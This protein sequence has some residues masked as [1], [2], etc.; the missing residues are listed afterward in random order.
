MIQSHLNAKEAL[1]RLVEGNRRFTQ[2]VRS[3]DALVSPLRR[4]ALVEAQFPHSIV[5]SCSDSRV[6]AEI[7]FDQGLGDLFVIRVAGN[8]IA[9]SLVGSVELAATLFGVELVVVMGHTR[10][11]AVSAT[12]DI[13][14]GK[15][16]APSANIGEI[17]ERIRPAVVEV[18]RPGMSR[19]ELIDAS[20]RANV[21]GSARQLRSVSPI[22]EN[23]IEEG[24]LSVVGAVYALESGEVTFFEDRA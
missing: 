23:R 17:V 20:I 7:V 16:R 11:G 2:N 24:R 14:Q 3:V 4:D 21:R 8:V 12:V 5:L 19:Q 22:L 1:A 10:C 15:S 9:P 6:P 13:V 18:S